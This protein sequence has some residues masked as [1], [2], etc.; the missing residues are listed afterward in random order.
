MAGAF[1]GPE[2]GDGRGDVVTELVVLLDLVAVVLPLVVV[3][4]LVD[5]GGGL[6]LEAGEFGDE[7]RIS[8]A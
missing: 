5:E 1:G 6:G 7:G 8:V 4:V 3:L 2:R